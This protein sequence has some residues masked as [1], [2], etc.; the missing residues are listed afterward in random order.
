M[1]SL[2]RL[3][4]LSLFLQAVSPAF[5]ST[6]ETAHSAWHFSGTINQKRVVDAVDDIL[7]EMNN[8]TQSLDKSN[9]DI[10]FEALR[11]LFSRIT[12]ILMPLVKDHR[13]A[14]NIFDI[15]IISDRLAQIFSGRAALPFANQRRNVEAILQRY[16]LKLN[17]KQSGVHD[18]ED[19]LIPSDKP[20]RIAITD[21]LQEVRSEM[22]KLNA[23]EIE[24]FFP[25]LIGL[26]RERKQNANPD[27]AAVVQNIVT[28]PRR[29]WIV[30]K[31]G[32]FSS[33][34]GSYC[35]GD[36]LPSENE[37]KQIDAWLEMKSLNGWGDP[38]G[39]FYTGGSASFDE[40]MGCRHT[41]YSILLRK[42]PNAPWRANFK[43]DV[44]M[45]AQSE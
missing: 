37:Q 34:G 24:L 5:S 43:P 22:R 45:P 39:T 40:M 25:S 44:A 32:E 33:R 27:A 1:K 2:H 42:Y 9:H 11:I 4:C 12:T 8:E 20:I 6:V 31:I 21:V 28:P 18:P 16:H 14:E 10:F 38:H 41:Q 3:I 36:S 35:I 13:A 29:S 17:K 30:R 15:T 19:S 23:D 7:D 26:V